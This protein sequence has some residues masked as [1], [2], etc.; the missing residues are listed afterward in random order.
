MSEKMR[1]IIFYI[2]VAISFGAI[3]VYNVLTPI[4]SD[5]LLFDSSQFQ[6]IGDIL[7]ETYRLYMTW[8]GRSVVQTIMNIFLCAPKWVFNI[9][10]SL[11]FV[12]LML[13]IYWNID[14]RKKFDFV[15]FALINL[16]VWMFGVSFGQSVLWISGA[17][18]YL[19][20]AAIIL[21]MVTLYRYK[22]ETQEKVKY[23][24]LLAV[25]MFVL[26]VFS[27]WCNENTSGGGL[28]LVLFGAGIYYYTHRKVKPWMITGVVGMFTGLVFMVLAPGNAKRS[29]SIEETHSG[30]MAL[31]ARFLK[32]NSAI[33]TY[34]LVM[35]VITVV[36]LVYLYLKG[37]KLM[38]MQ[39]SIAFMAACVATS[40]ALILTKS[41]MDRAYFGA[42]IFMTIA[43]V[44]AIAYIPEKEAVLGTLKYAGT[45][46]L[47]IYMFFSY[48][49][50][51][52]DLMRIMR[53]LD[54]RE[55]YVEEQKAQGN[56]DLVVPMLRPE[57]DNK[58]TFIYTNK[59]DV[60][61]NPDEWGSQLYKM[62]YG[63]D[64]LVGVPR[65]EWTEY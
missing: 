17:C 34:F 48:C 18:N 15:I 13:L 7:K 52:A 53:E 59:N 31:F 44:Q 16:L 50:N 8:N 35:I 4:M 51:G 10:N 42:G 21:S 32:I 45:I 27:G 25:A 19:W 30:I 11:C 63:V 56:Y 29:A 38:E 24:K 5:D 9:C 41:P 60:T 40:Y 33:S 54:E 23:S 20:G 14:G 1:K 26:G 62:Y 22:L 6:S 47:L 43:C 61:E 58:Y 65:E 55:A 37:T 46:C 39:W 2:S 57:F 12:Y 36:I 49:E 3:Y 28:L 64:S